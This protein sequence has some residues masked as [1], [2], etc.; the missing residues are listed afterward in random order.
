[1]NM[2]SLDDS[3]TFSCGPQ[4]GC[5]NQC[6]RDLNQYLTPYDILRLRTHFELTSGEFLQRYTSEH[7]GPETGLPIITLKT[8]PSTELICPF[9]SPEGCRVYDNRPS[10]CRM[11]PLARALTRSRETGRLTEYF[12]LLQEPHCKGFQGEQ[13]QTVRQWLDHQGLHTYNTMNDL[14]ME[15][16]SLKNQKLQGPLDM[17]SGRMFFLACYDLDRFREKVFREHFLDAPD[18]EPELIQR[19]KEE[20][21][22]LLKLGLEWIRRTLFQ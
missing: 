3:F 9:V 14:M 18:F 19:A 6:C 13:T 17:K 20:D 5:F 12:M 1:M 15:I 4:R 10:S 8:D 16:I 7:I 21:V 11:Y 2:L 22:A